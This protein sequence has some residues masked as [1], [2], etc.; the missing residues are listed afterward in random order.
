MIYI[1]LVAMIFCHIID[2][3]VLQGV[4]SKLKQRK[5]WEENAPQKLYKHDYIIALIEHSF[6]WTCSIHIPILLYALLLYS[7]KPPIIYIVV[8]VYNWAVHAFVDHLKAN[9]LKINLTQDQTIHI[10]QIAVSW[11]VYFII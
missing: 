5:W 2:D 9:A 10:L 4:L 7:P 11:M 6:S 3:Y 8:F 1:V